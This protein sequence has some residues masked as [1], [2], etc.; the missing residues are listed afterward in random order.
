MWRQSSEKVEQTECRKVGVSRLSELDKREIM[1]LQLIE[2]HPLNSSSSQFR[3]VGVTEVVDELMTESVQ[4]RHRSNQ[5]QGSRGV[6]VGVSLSR[7][8][9]CNVLIEIPT[10]EVQGKLWF[11]YSE[12][13]AGVVGVVKVWRAVSKLCKSGAMF[14]LCITLGRRYLVHCQRK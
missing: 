7:S 14:V 1:W 5:S 12:S 9:G 3:R 13:V 8:S 6:L 10:T 4:S 11:K 2:L